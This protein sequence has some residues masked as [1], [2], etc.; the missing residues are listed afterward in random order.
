MLHQ[1][2]GPRSTVEQLLTSRTGPADDD[3]PARLNGEPSF[4]RIA[5]PSRTAAPEPPRG[6]YREPT[7]TT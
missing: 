3:E 6:E 5:R 2:D 1:S 4:I 7:T